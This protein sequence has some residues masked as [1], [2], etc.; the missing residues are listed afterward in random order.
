MKSLESIGAPWGTALME[1]T[2]M[3]RI[4]RIA[5]KLVD[6]S[7]FGELRDVYLEGA[8]IFAKEAKIRG[9]GVEG[10]VRVIVG[11]RMSLWSGKDRYASD[12]QVGITLFDI[13]AGQFVMVAGIV[14]GNNVKYRQDIV[15]TT[16]EP[17]EP[18][19][20]ATAIR[21]AGRKTGFWRR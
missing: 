3:A 6:A 9:M 5:K 11:V 19:D 21:I 20:V 15:A 8:R 7:V 12:T 16:G 4:D 10:P 14:D 2:N 13:P 1:K 18:N 17:L